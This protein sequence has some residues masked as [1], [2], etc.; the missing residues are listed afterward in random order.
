LAR[1]E[2]F[3]D[4]ASHCV[5]ICFH[6]SGSSRLPHTISANH[7]SKQIFQGRGRT[8]DYPGDRKILTAD[9]VTVQIHVVDIQIN[10]EPVARDVPV[11]AI[12]FPERSSNDTI[13]QPGNP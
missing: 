9:R 7:L 12:R 8:T 10:H 1:A 11:L 6:P 3:A 5:S 2:R 4:A 13:I